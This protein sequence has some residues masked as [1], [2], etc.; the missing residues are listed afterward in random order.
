MGTPTKAQILAIKYVIKNGGEVCPWPPGEAATPL[1][2]ERCVEAGWLTKSNPLLGSK[3]TR[4]RVTPTGRRAA[5]NVYR[6]KL[7]KH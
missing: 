1:V 7:M 2:R 4:W 3:L 5:W 6:R